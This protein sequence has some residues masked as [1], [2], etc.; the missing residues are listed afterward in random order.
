MN[1]KQFTL[2]LSTDGFNQYAYISVNLDGMTKEEANCVRD[3]AD[4]FIDAVREIT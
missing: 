2:S 3:M 1:K 4:A